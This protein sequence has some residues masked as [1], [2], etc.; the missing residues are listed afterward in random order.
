MK[1]SDFVY[2][3]RNHSIQIIVFTKSHIHRFWYMLGQLFLM[4][5]T[6]YLSTLKTTSVL[7]HMF[8]YIIY[9]YIYFQNKTES[10]IHKGIAWLHF[11]VQ[12]TIC[13]LKMQVYFQCFLFLPTRDRSKEIPLLSIWC[14][15]VTVN[16]S[17]QYLGLY[18]MGSLT[19][20]L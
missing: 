14:I 8:P 19:S 9:I 5:L 12:N 4:S 6:N 18:K 3:Y 13:V 15:Q 17:L 7:F 20:V 11:Y 16:S 10:G 1:V 2:A